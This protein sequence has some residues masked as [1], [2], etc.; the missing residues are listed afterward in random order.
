MNYNNFTKEAYKL[1]RSKGKKLEVITSIEEKLSQGKK[2]NDDQRE[3]LSQKES[4]TQ[5]VMYYLEVMSIYK[6]EVDKAL[7]Q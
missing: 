7:L 2:I 1:V 4:L 6:A 3:K 5:S